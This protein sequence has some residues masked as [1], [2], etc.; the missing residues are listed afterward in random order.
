MLHGHLRLRPRTAATPEKLPIVPPPRPVEHAHAA[1]HDR[2]PGRPIQPSCPW[3]G[4]RQFCAA[5][6][7]ALSAVSTVGWA[8]TS[9]TAGRSA[10]RLRVNQPLLTITKFPL[11]G[12]W[13]SRNSPAR[14]RNS[15][16]E[17]GR[18]GLDLAI[19]KQEHS[20]Q[21]GRSG[22]EARWRGERSTWS[23]SSITRHAGLCGARWPRPAGRAG[24]RWSCPVNTPHNRGCCPRLSSRGFPTGRGGRNE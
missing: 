18:V 16:G 14:S 9:R 15:R 4:P 22:R 23:T 13:R 7:A 8:A 11:E 1:M 5:C 21:P 19:R 24:R 2:L 20:S 12:C 3:S 10:G 6:A 17:R